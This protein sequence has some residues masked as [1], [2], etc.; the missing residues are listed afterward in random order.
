MTEFV[1]IGILLVITRAVTFI[2]R[3]TIGFKRR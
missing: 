3:V 1:K 2:A